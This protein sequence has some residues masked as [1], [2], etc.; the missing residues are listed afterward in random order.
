MES[1]SNTGKPQPH[2]PSTDK[3]R[4][5]AS[6]RIP[7]FFRMS[8]A[9]RIDALHERGLLSDE[10]T[11]L[12]ADAG[13]T[14][15][16]PTADK[17][18]ENVVGVFG[19]PMGVALNFLVNGRDYVVPLAVEEASIVA[20][21]SGIG[22]LTRLSGGFTASNPDPILI[23]Q[24]Q[25]VG[26]TDPAHAK[27]QL[28][29][30]KGELLALANS[31]H[32]NMVARGGGARDI[33]VH[34]HSSS[35]GEHMVVLH[36]L[37]DT[38]EAMGANLVN[39]M[40]EGIAALVETI[41]GGKVFLRILSNL[42][43]RA[44]ATASVR[45][46]V[47]NLEGRG[48]SGEEV[49]DGIVLASDL[50]QVDPYRATTHNKGI[51]NGVDAL[52]IATGNDW[53]AIESAAHA[54]AARGGRYKALSRW[55]LNTEGD[56]VGEIE[57]PIKVG[58]VGGSVD[59]NPS[60]RICHRLLGSP[61]AGEL[62]G[63]LAAVGLAQNLAALRAL[64]TDGIQKGH[65]TLHARSVATTAGVPEAV[66]DEVVE[67]LIES[68]EIKAWKAREI[69]QDL[70]RKVT[71]PERAERRSACGKV[72]VLGEH[73]A[74]YGRPAIALPIPLAVEAVAQ[75]GGDGVHV[76]IPR[77]GLE[78]QVKPGL[79]QGVNGA[80]NTML[81]SL[82][83][84]GVAMTIE[85]MPHL[86]R[87]MGLGGSAALAVAVLRA[88]SHEFRLELDDA[89]VNRL[90]F[91]SEKTAHGTPSGIDNTVATYGRPLVFRKDG[92]PAFR[93]LNLPQPVPLVLGLTGRESLTART[94]ARVGVARQDHP[95]RIEAI[96]DQMAQLADAGV[97]ALEAARF[98]ELG[99]LMDLCQGYLNAL[100]VSSPELEELIHIARRNGALGAKLT[101]G[102]GGG[103]MIALCPGEQQRVAAAMEAAGYKTLVLSPG[104]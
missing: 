1:K 16:L 26:T 44:I 69:A 50:A 43:D 59:T 18:I 52:A 47:K 77:W 38:R 89:T 63:I 67:G 97:E 104:I 33:E 45:V 55:Y 37:V 68:G 32:P 14:L 13:H 24:V 28:L 88:L 83:L 90:A 40:C 17:M 19:L 3:R 20:G 100:Q 92:E 11:S 36:L 12:L 15:R 57:I 4:T 8:I 79:S 27:S 58:T 103:T 25:A 78:Q 22:R 2:E 101:G 23:G 95:A 41:T 80:I 87:G 98:D 60:A 102:G 10:D 96:F 72:I 29:A 49:R 53:R 84:T 64:A 62:A 71:T 34:V 21:L 9:E 65:M 76:L 85:L 5:E 7:N 91:E 81:Q 75:K 48:Y 54:F 61:S 35:A 70:A 94:V 51:M 99:H 82:D 93:E 31:L 30:R 6:S 74:V 42:T 66:F 73:A 86:P 56:L 46:P 39:T